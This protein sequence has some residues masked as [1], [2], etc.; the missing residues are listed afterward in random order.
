MKK[1]YKCKHQKEATSPCSICKE[2][3]GNYSGGWEKGCRCS[4]CGKL[5]KEGVIRGWKDGK[6]DK[7]YDEEW[8]EVHD[9]CR[10]NSKEQ[11]EIE[12]KR[13]EVE[14]AREKERNKLHNPDSPLPSISKSE[15]KDKIVYEIACKFCGQYWRHEMP[16]DEDSK[17]RAEEWLVKAYQM[18]QKE[19][20]SLT[21]ERERERERE[22][23]PARILVATTNALFVAK[24]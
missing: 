16:K 1:I 3:R 2:A 18:H 13:E 23:R 8:A 10:S 17:K 11:K 6:L 7:E 19:F 4:K 14:E 9:N 24:I 21:A 20:A 12:R 5:I 22:R 15:L